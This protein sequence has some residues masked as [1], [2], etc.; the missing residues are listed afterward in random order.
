MLQK[1]IVGVLGTTMATLVIAIAYNAIR[2]NFAISS[3][4]S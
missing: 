1:N 4:S 2:G 3:A